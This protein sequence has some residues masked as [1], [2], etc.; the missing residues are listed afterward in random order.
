LTKD[1][2][3]IGSGIIGSSSAWYLTKIGYRVTI[4]DQLV[5]NSSQENPRTGTSA[6][7]G[8][9]MGNIFSRNNGRAWELRK[10]SLSLWEIWL[11]ELNNEKENIKIE[12]PLIKLAKSEK[13][14]FS[15]KEMIKLKQDRDIEI[16]SPGSYNHA[17]PELPVNQYGGLISHNDGRINPQKLNYLFLYDALKNNLNR[18]SAFVKTIKRGANSNSIKW[19]LTLSE[20]STI[21][22]DVILISSAMNSNKLLESLGYK[23]NLQPVIGQGICL[24]TEN[25]E[26]ED[27]PSVVNFRGFNLI[28]N[29][30]NKLIIG[31]T[32]E[33]T[34]MPN[35]NELNDMKNLNGLAP[36]WIKSSNIKEQWYGIRAKPTNQGAP[37]LKKL[38]EGLI[39]S[40]GHYRNGI[41]I[42]PA[43]AEWVAKQ[44]D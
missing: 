13:E 43:C 11:R 35:I 5:T 26:W 18:I 30:S 36:D 17:I 14:Y 40:T 27:W 12:T 3:V 25:Y 29:G 39:V 28:P 34:N 1:I 23:I 8:V 20:G 9:L 10:R 24:E 41:L 7:L 31:A 15:M 38:E 42:A 4:I 21:Q 6:S 2:T 19:S 22:T 33:H 37:I 44:I 32:I 16:I